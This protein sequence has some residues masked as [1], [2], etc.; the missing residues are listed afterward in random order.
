MILT[1]DILD[2]FI[3]VVKNFGEFI[4][5]PLCVSQILRV[6]CLPET[7][8]SRSIITLTCLYGHLNCAS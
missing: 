3:L 5:V 4:S 6:Q 2:L 1:P 7:V 8:K